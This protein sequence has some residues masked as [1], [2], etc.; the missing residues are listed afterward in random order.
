MNREIKFRV[1]SKSCG[2]YLKQYQ[3]SKAIGLYIVT[4]FNNLYSNICYERSDLVFEQFTGTLDKNGVEIYEGDII[5]A[6]NS[7]VFSKEVVSWLDNS[8]GWF[9]FASQFS[10][11]TYFKGEPSPTWEVIGNINQNSDMFRPQV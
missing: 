11:V 3:G 10:W 7:N 6:T 4:P 2:A 9:P 8:T 5:I 1:W